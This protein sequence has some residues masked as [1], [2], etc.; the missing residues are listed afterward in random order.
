MINMAMSMLPMLKAKDI[1]GSLR[2]TNIEKMTPK[3]IRPKPLD[4]TLTVLK[5][6]CTRPCCEELVVFTIIVSRQGSINPSLTAP[7][8][9]ESTSK[10]TNNPVLSAELYSSDWIQY[11]NG[12]NAM[13]IH[14]SK[15][16]DPPARNESLIPNCFT[17]HRKYEIGI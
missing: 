4:T 7:S 16:S 5:H 9:H 3:N 1:I 15:L 13:N 6:P 12:D 11:G 14:A 8:K 17:I 2:W 10:Q